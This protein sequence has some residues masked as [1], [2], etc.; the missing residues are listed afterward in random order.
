MIVRIWDDEY[1]TANNWRD[2]IETCL[3]G[4]D[5]ETIASDSNEI[6]DELS[7]LHNRRLSFLDGN[8]QQSEQRVSQ[9]DDTDILIV[10]NDLYELRGF[11]DYTAEMV[12]MRAGVYTDCA[13]IV[14]VN[15]T[16][17]SDFDLT[18]LGHPSS[19]ADL[20]INGDFVDNRVL[21]YGS[22]EDSSEFRPW[23]WP[24]L[25]AT[26]I[27]FKTR[28]RVLRDFLSSKDSHTTT[29]LDFLQFPPEARDR[30]SRRARAFLHPHK[31]AETV[32]FW[33]FVTDN[34]AAVNGKE[35]AK[36][37]E[38]LD[39]DKLARVTSRRISC[40]L[41][42]LVLGPQN[43]IVDLPHVVENFPFVV[44]EDRRYSQDKWDMYANFDEAPIDEVE[45]SLNVERCLVDWLD[46]PV[47]WAHELANEE[48]VNRILASTDHNPLGLVFCEDTSSFQ[49]ASKCR[50][51]F[52]S[53]G[54]TS[55]DRFVSWLESRSPP[56]KYAPQSR[57]TT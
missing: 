49:S 53:H 45:E 55:D 17:D 39:T 36:I 43:L 8:S 4:Q 46:R 52:A 9:L 16:P 7:E 56:I 18:L 40:W 34:E 26:P 21:W 23:H 11:S 1:G 42:W 44:P 31:D 32:T 22:S 6:H 47:F 12:A 24:T 15:L 30:L 14:V 33:D 50:R 28:V 37:G 41:S 20:H 48:N 13:Y 27:S 5:V 38:Y 2:L 57:F 35:G 19:K 51:F 3:D 54:S 10:D 29:I 25:L